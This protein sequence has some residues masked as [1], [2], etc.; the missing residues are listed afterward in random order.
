MGRARGRVLVLAWMRSFGRFCVAL[1]SLRCDGE[2]SSNAS[3]LLRTVRASSLPA[4]S[5]KRGRC[6][7]RTASGSHPTAQWAIRSSTH[8]LHARVAA[9]VARSRYSVTDRPQTSQ[10]SHVCGPMQVCGHRRWSADFACVQ[11]SHVTVRRLHRHTFDFTATCLHT[12]RESKPPMC[13]GAK[14]FS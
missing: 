13:G 12:C 5:I 8:Q 2:V 10:T 7:C 3:S 14:G 1:A 4:M 11:T 6:G 9:A